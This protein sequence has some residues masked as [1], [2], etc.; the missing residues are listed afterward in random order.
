[1]TV[2]R[3]ALG[4]DRP[5]LRQAAAWLA[6]R[7]APDGGGVWDLSAL[8]LVLP[9]SRAVRRLRELL[10]EHAADRRLILHPPT[11]V[12]QGR[13]ADELASADA[14]VADE[15]LRLLAWMTA[16]RGAE[17]TDRDRLVPTPPGDD[18]PAGWLAAAQELADL[19]REL[20]GRRLRP[21]DVAPALTELAF[22][23]EP[24][25]AA[26]R[27]VHERYLSLLAEQGRVDRDEH[28]LTVAPLCDRQVV[29]IACVDLPAMTAEMLLQLTTPAIA[30]VPAP[31]DVLD[32]F[33]AF[34]SLI[35]A[36]WAGADI[37]LADDQLSIVGS[38]RDQAHEVLRVL[39]RQAAQLTADQITIGVGDEAA[40]AS[41]E[42]ALRLA[43]LPARSALGT[44]LDR[45]AAVRLLAGLGRFIGARRF[46]DLAA[47]LRHPDVEDYVRDAAG[48][49]AWITLLD[50]YANDHL[51][52]RLTGQWLGDEPTRARM[53]QVHD[54]I[55]ALAPVGSDERRPLPHW[56]AVLAAALERVYGDRILSLQ[57]PQDHQLIESLGA[58]GD[59][60]RAIAALDPAASTTPTTT[61]AQSVELLLTLMRGA[62]VP[63]M[64][65]E[66]AIELLGWL[67]LALDDAPLLVIT[68]L[69]EGHIPASRAADPWLPD[70][71][72]RR[73]GLTDDL[74]R[75][76]RDK[77]LLTIMLH[78][79]D[80][81]R[82]IACRRTAEGDPLTPSRLL[83]ACDAPTQARRILSF[84]E[85]PP[86]FE[87][88]LMLIPC[89]GGG[90]DIPRPVP[91]AQPLDH[92][93]VTAF[94]DYIA[95]PY[96]FYLKHVL[97]LA[98]VSD[99]AVEM[100]PDV[101]GTIAHEVLD[102]F[103]RDG[104]WA[105]DNAQAL[106]ERLGELLDARALA[107]FGAEPG[108]AVRLQCHLLRERLR[109]FARWH[110]RQYEAGWRV[111]GVEQKLRT[112]IDVDGR[113]FTI[114]G[115]IDRIDRH[116]DGRYRVMD[117]KTA[118]RGTTPEAAH[119][120]G[121][122]D[123]RTWASLQLPLYRLL[124]QTLGIGEPIELGYVVLPRDAGRSGF[125]PATWTADELEDARRRAIE[126]IRAIR[127]GVFWPPASHSGDDAF[128]GICL[129]ETLDRPD[130]LRRAEEA[131][132]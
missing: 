124:V 41:I 24:R 18:E 30:L 43:N 10:A 45:T 51:Q 121:R 32:R 57:R 84:Y 105:S 95:C 61:F 91:P 25:W 72:R 122:R 76:A 63:P 27:R 28:L 103:G 52:R 123:A 48:V 86:T 56:A 118:D 120:T 65:G 17:P 23:D 126:I 20:A 131:A 83:L 4:W 39:E 16:L 113:P 5:I 66:P 130:A 54:A 132:S 7:F 94:A 71:V 88:P 116:A 127:A 92:L 50:R 12:T 107:R 115:R 62:A 99:E 13:L 104:A 73:L 111:V 128:A 55:L 8:L 14:A 21:A 109:H 79:R 114:S 106:S 42:Q 19:V 108:A 98:T 125:E 69:N 90:F 93:P 96:R 58:I 70:S 85:S 129:D 78:S 68:G 26:L 9:G 75:L 117:Y 38:P 67:E 81:V 40:A 119:R 29:L 82:A 87:P 22:C 35:A 112:Q 11:I 80:A 60:L 15:G 74:R 97:K 2:E 1:M 44:P 102:D 100:G 31:E 49:A 33:D 3:H 46:D 89:G 47:L 6:G 110:A 37:D 59:G 77:L 53:R 36:S 101:F 64:A 34:G